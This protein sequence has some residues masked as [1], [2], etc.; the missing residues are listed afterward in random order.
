[1]SRYKRSNA[2]LA[3]PSTSYRPSAVKPTTKSAKTL[4]L[5]ESQL[6]SGTFEHVIFSPH[7]AVEGVMID[8]DQQRVQ[9]VLE[10]HDEAAALPFTDML[11]GQALQVRA[12]RQGP[13]AKGISPHPVYAFQSLKSIDGVAPSKRR[14]ATDPGY[15]GV[16]VRLNYARHGSPNG[17]VL[18]SGDFLHLKPNGMKQFKLKVGDAVQA[19]GDAQF[20]ATGGGW[21]VEVESINGKTVR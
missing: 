7:G 14:R 13:S 4:S 15:S 12:T 17:V 19:L 1:M 11:P 3:V 5:A 10:P 18:D 20:L 16:V 2:A 6:L 8:V 21:A 9:L